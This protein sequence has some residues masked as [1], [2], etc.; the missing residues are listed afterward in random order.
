M[1]RPPR[2]GSQCH[3][4]KSRCFRIGEAQQADRGDRAL[5]RR[6][7]ARAGSSKAACPLQG[8]SARS[9]VVA[10]PGPLEAPA[11]QNALQSASL[12]A[13]FRSSSLRS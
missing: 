1:T 3:D 13:G 7:I 5:A 9:L 6:S 8:S 4:A 2:T 11:A 12:K 10:V